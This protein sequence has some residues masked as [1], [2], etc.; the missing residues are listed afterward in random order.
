MDPNNGLNKRIGATIP[1]QLSRDAC[2]RTLNMYED[3]S[4]PN[5]IIEEFFSPRNNTISLNFGN[6]KSEM[7]RRLEDLTSLNCN[8]SA[9]TNVAH[10]NYS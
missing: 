2:F 6:D 5:A 9:T 10:D 1:Q 4:F 7:R 8:N 3:V